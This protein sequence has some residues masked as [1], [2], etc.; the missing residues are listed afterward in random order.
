[1]SSHGL[2]K[3]KSLVHYFMSIDNDDGVNM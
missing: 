2:K 3:C 1:L